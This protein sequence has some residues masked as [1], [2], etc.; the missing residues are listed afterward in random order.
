[1]GTSRSA[2]AHLLDPENPSMTRVVAGYLNIRQARVK[3]RIRLVG[4]RIPSL[5]WLP[6]CMT[7]PCKT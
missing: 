5:K 7:M 4:I 1:M 3:P 2:L 6:S